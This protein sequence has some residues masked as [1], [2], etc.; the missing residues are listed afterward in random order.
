MLHTYR[1]IKFVHTAYS[2]FRSLNTISEKQAAAATII[3]LLLK[4]KK[5][6]K[7]RQKRKVWV[8]PWL[9]RRRSLGVYETLLA[10]LWLEDECNY[11]NY[12]R[13]TSENFEEI[14]QLIKYDIRKENTNMREPIPPRLKLAATIRF[15]ATGVSYKGLQIQYRI[16]N[17]TLSL[18]VPEV[19]QA[20]F[21][22]L[23]EKYIKVTV[24][25]LLWCSENKMTL[26]H[27]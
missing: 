10:E 16:H 27:K 12:L 8:K 22:R 7:S 18:F 9:K 3:A 11:K 24:Q 17:S 26:K 19:S 13:M 21:N 1:V 14:F 5:K 25:T 15:L 20:I 6:R 23:K 4:K 2:I